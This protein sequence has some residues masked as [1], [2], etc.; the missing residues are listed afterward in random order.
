[1]LSDRRHPCFRNF[2]SVVSIDV[3][4]VVAKY[5]LLG[6]NDC[7]CV[8]VC[9]CVGGGGGGRFFMGI[10]VIPRENEDNAYPKFWGANFGRYASGRFLKEIVKGP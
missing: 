7:A 5:G 9:V 2:D 3:I 10:T 1:M 8:C 6:Y 4:L